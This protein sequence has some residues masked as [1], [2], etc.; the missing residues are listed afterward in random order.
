MPNTVYYEDTSFNDSIQDGYS[1]ISLIGGLYLRSTILN[2]IPNK[3][4]YD[5]ISLI[6]DYLGVVAIFNNA[7]KRWMFP[8]SLRKFDNDRIDWESASGVPYFFSI[9]SHRYLAI[10]KKPISENY[11]Q[12]Y[13][14]YRASA[15][16]LGPNDLLALPDQFI[17]VLDDYTMSDLWEQNQ[18]W[19]K[20][21]TNFQAY[22]ANLE[23]L[24]I[25]IRSNRY[26]DRTPL[27]KG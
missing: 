9:V 17:T 8:S 13:V 14:F 23:K 27:L 26:P 1:E 12:M 7:I 5:M 21:A 20:A 24:R 10:Y 18:E 11:G 15:P 16:N 19:G 25:W 22:I 6:P 3:S 2:F 4:Y